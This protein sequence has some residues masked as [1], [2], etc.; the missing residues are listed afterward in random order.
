MARWFG[1]LRKTPKDVATHF[2]FDYLPKRTFL[3]AI[4]VFSGGNFTNGFAEIECM[5][6]PEFKSHSTV[7][8]VVV[9]LS[10]MN[11]IGWED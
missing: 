2:F 11:Y 1:L 5:Y 10:A 8:R 3:N 7:L 4:C 9:E 6:A